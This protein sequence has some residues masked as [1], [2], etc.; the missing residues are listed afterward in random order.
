MYYFLYLR[1]SFSR[2]WREHVLLLLLLACAISL[3]LSLSIIDASNLNGLTQQKYHYTRNHNYRIRN[4]EPGDESIFEAYP[5]LMTPVWDDGELYV[6]R[7]ANNPLRRDPENGTLIIDNFVT[8]VAN[9]TYQ[10]RTSP[11]EN[12]SKARRP[13]PFVPTA[14]C[15]ACMCMYSDRCANA[16]GFG[17]APAA[18]AIGGRIPR[19]RAGISIACEPEIVAIYYNI[20]DTSA[21]AA[22]WCGGYCP[23]V[24]GTGFYAILYRQRDTI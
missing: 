16:C 8:L 7:T 9:L 6:D 14:A 18:A 15:A 13:D 19:E 12:P 3:P 5:D 2:A 21:A 20:E 23:A 4:A 17:T 22:G 11:M 24:S 1:R 10:Y